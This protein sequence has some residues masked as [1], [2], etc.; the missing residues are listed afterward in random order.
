MD[1]KDQQKTPEERYSATANNPPVDPRKP[2]PRTTPG[3]HSTGGARDHRTEG[4][5]EGPEK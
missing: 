5:S 3:S 4:D 1:R 2:K